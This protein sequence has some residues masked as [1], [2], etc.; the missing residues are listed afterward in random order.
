MTFFGPIFRN[1]PK[2]VDHQYTVTE[3]V[4]ARGPTIRKGPVACWIADILKVD[5]VCGA[6]LMQKTPHFPYMSSS[7]ED[8]SSMF[9]FDRPVLD[10]NLRFH[11]EKGVQAH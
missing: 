1:Y 4:T 11:P 5:I 6:V 3:G 10:E 8:S 9:I 7:F 2:P